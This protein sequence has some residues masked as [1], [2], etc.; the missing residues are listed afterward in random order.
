MQAVSDRERDREMGRGREVTWDG[1]NQRAGV[2]AAYHK[3][4]EHASQGMQ[5]LWRDLP[6]NHLP[7]T[8]QSRELQVREPRSQ[9]VLKCLRKSTHER[10]RQVLLDWP[11][12]PRDLSCKI[13]QG[14][15]FMKPPRQMS[16]VPF[17]PPLL[18]QNT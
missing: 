7:Q 16:S 1:L 18:P 9:S 4:V 15:G 10:K 6:R 2:V 17:P 8:Y 11:H 13:C 3:Q 14:P 12:P 5:E